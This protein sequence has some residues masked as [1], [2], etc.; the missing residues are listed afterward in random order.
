[1]FQPGGGRVVQTTASNG[2]EIEAPGGGS[3]VITP[4]FW[5]HHQIWFMNIDARNIRASSGLAGA[6]A[7]RNWLPALPDGTQLGPRPADLQDRYRILYEKFGTAWRVTPDNALFDYAPGTSTKDFT[8]EEWPVGESPQ[9]CTLPDGREPQRPLELAEAEAVCRKIVDKVAR[10]NCIQDVAATGEVSFAEVYVAGERIE[11]NTP[12]KPPQLVSPEPFSLGLARSLSF[13][14]QPAADQD[15]DPVT[16]EHCL[17]PVR[18]R[19]MRQRHC[20]DVGDGKVQSRSVQLEPSSA[21]Y[22]KL[23]ASDSEGGKSES[24]TRRFHTE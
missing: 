20:S 21:Y 19:F 15:G 8:L 10:G 5:N 9:S 11:R 18:E 13:I 14:W 7:S 4:Q 12:P 3:V 17:W 2:I 22:W 6:I 1:L 23:L 24:E 16:Y